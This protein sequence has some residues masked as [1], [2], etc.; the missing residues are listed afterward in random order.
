[1]C[2]RT[3][4]L[5]HLLSVTKYK[6]SRNTSHQTPAALSLNQPHTHSCKPHTDAITYQ[7]PNLSHPSPLYIS[8]PSTLPFILISSSSPSVFSSSLIML[9]K[10]IK[11]LPVRWVNAVVSSLHTETFKHRAE[12][13]S[14]G[15]RG[16]G[17]GGWREREW[18]CW[19][20]G[21]VII[22]DK[23]KDERES[24]GGRDKMAAQPEQVIET[25]LR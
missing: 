20:R 22:S 3:L 12:R 21:W 25:W 24:W 15:R 4:H 8:F 11:S 1:M 13:R 10:P 9:I 7:H 2:D 18:G 17:K 5:L 23:A 16:K 19:R 14:E 6:Y